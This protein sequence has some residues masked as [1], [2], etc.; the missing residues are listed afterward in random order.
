MG[1]KSLIGII[2]SLF[3]TVICSGA[4]ICVGVSSYNTLK[5]ENAGEQTSSS[6][7]FWGEGHEDD[8][9]GDSDLGL[10]IKGL[11]NDNTLTVTSGT[12]S[13]SSAS[14]MNS[15][16]VSLTDFYMDF[17]DVYSP[18]LDGTIG[19][20]CS[21]ETTPKENID[22]TYE[23]DVFYL[24]CKELS[25][26]KLKF[27]C[28][29]V[30]ES[31]NTFKEAGVIKAMIP[32][33][34]KASD[35][36]LTEILNEVES[37]TNN[38]TESI[39]TDSQ[40]NSTYT[41]GLAFDELTSGTTVI[42]NINMTLVANETHDLTSIK[43]SSPL[44]ITQGS[45]EDATSLSLSLDLNLKDDFIPEG[46]AALTDAEKA[47]YES[48][49]NPL[50]GIANLPSD[51]DLF[52]ADLDASITKDSKETHLFGQMNVSTGFKDSAFDVDKLEMFGDMTLYE[53]VETSKLTGV[54]SNDYS[55][56]LRANHFLEFS[57]DPYTEEDGSLNAEIT[58]EY[59][60][61]MHVKM[62]EKDIESIYD[63]VCNIGDSNVLYKYTSSLASS[64]S[65]GSVPIMDYFKNGNYGAIED[66]LVKNIDVVS[67][68]S[69]QVILQ[70][71][72][73][74]SMID[75]EAG[76]DDVYSLI[77]TISLVDS[78][79]GVTKFQIKSDYNG[80][81]I[82]ITLSLKALDRPSGS[83]DIFSGIA[84]LTTDSSSNPIRSYTKTAI[85]GTTSTGTIMLYNDTSKGKFI[86]MDYLPLF[87][88]IGINTTENHFYYL[89]G[90]LQ[91]SAGFGTWEVAKY[92]M[93][94]HA[95]IN[96]DDDGNVTAYL[97]FVMK[98]NYDM[99]DSDFYSTEFFIDESGDAYV[100]HNSTDTSWSWFVS[101]SK[102]TS[103]VFKI[104]RDEILKNFVYYVVD[105]TMGIREMTLGDTI[106]NKIYDSLTSSSDAKLL[107]DYENWIYDTSY[108]ASDRKFTTGLALGNVAYLG[109]DVLAL[110]NVK[111]EI[112]HTDAS[113]DSSILQTIKIYGDNSANTI[114]K[115]ASVVNLN[116][117]LT[118]TFYA[119]KD[120]TM[121]RYT[122]FMNFYKA[123]TDAK[124]TNYFEITDGQDSN[125]G[126]YV[127]Y[128]NKQ[129]TSDFSTPTDAYYFHKSTNNGNLF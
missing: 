20:N 22:V 83:S 51:L 43:T 55:S 73:G 81:A 97:A 46:Y 70:F 75:S 8:D 33:A 127:E 87:V 125:N 2:S 60:D 54:A 122:E 90:E 74:A 61:T 110:Q 63:D 38:V 52:T 104:T 50:K 30:L 27:T 26:D 121:P 29:S 89:S 17:N 49:D 108:S 10:V 41:F 86:S 123:Q 37:G 18:S 71:D 67:S 112:T 58:A 5:G 15:I 111:I 102:V 72:I 4:S 95:E 80:Q 34:E 106:M 126:N 120:N 44:V 21:G 9:T 62:K 129:K 92:A 64:D 124:L 88:Q 40:G 35:I 56:D 82:D 69:T 103:R 118:A 48:L 42:S 76:E 79:W 1:R 96:I 109:S 94:L 12:A 13:L 3:L 117:S 101:Y 59:R 19:L 45:G 24:Y 107:T 36:D 39:A 57:Y 32:E 31:V 68:S 100:C 119:G 16:N 128:S 115:I 25:S 77:A 28:S 105:L 47:E 99:S 113:A 93:G 84:S 114:M 53:P 78:S 14:I 91:F 65:S 85:D 98:E 116:L 7:S 66:G 23:D 6:S 11:L